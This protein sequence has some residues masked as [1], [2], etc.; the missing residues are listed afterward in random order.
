MNPFD[1]KSESVEAKATAT[2]LTKGLSS[3]FVRPGIT[4]CSRTSV[5]IPRSAAIATTG[6][7]L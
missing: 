4:F 6:P 3:R 5:G 1:P 7:E 2:A